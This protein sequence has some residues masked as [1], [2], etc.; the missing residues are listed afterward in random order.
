[1]FKSEF[2]VFLHNCSLLCSG[3]AYPLKWGGALN[4][5]PDNGCKGDLKLFVKPVAIFIL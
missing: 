4:Y 2:W 5:N 1:M 3:Y